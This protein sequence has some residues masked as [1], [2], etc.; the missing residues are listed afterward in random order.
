MIG[1][2][3]G[4]FL[5]LALTNMIPE[6]LKISKNKNILTIWMEIASISFGVYLMYLIAIE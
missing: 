4:G 1:F 3:T 5:F 2:T 6:I